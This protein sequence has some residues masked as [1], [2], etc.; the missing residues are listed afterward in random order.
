[1]KDLLI[2]IVNW[3]TTDLTLKCLKS[4]HKSNLKLSFDIA[5]VDNGS[6]DKTIITKVKNIY[7]DVIIH[8]S[9]KN[10]GFAGGNNIV[11]KKYSND[12]SYS[13]LLNSDTEV[14]SNVIDQLIS[15][16]RR[17][18]ADVSSCTLVNPN[19]KLQAN[20]GQLPKLLPMFLWISGIDDIFRM[21]RIRVPSYQERCEKYYKYSHE[22]GWLAGT[23]M[24]IK[25]EVF[26]KVGFLDEAI[27]MYSEDTDYCLRAKSFGFKVYFLAGPKIMHIGGA[28][29]KEPQYKQWK[30]ELDGLRYLIN[31]HYLKS[32]YYLYLI[33]VRVFML[34]RSL[35]FALLGNKNY[36][37]IYFK[38]FQEF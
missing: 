32:Y 4:I 25:R 14:K 5:L 15:E 19:G 30:G 20:V 29:S 37:K 34:F 21:F 26:K 10:L 28:S 13:L 23:A 3:N 2:V 31:K 33:L 17:Y 35:V 27:F 18:G 8:E 38:L 1:M 22:V 36:A 16:A 7:P 11:L 6:S 24:L 12:Y 9:D